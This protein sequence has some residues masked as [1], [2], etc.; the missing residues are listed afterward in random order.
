[1]GTWRVFIQSCNFALSTYYVAGSELDL[2]QG[3]RVQKRT[4]RGELIGEK[5]NEVCLWVRRNVCLS[6]TAARESVSIYREVLSK[7][8]FRKVPHVSLLGNHKD[9][10]I[11]ES[12]GRG[13]ILPQSCSGGR[14]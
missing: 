5:T 12:Y 14:F 10:R 13:W 7:K 9:G 11:G 4:R 3:K 8:S 6:G 1:M 2:E